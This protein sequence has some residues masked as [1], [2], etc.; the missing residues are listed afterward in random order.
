MSVVVGSGIAGLT[1]CLKVSEYLKESASESTRI[2]LITKAEKDETNT[3]YAQGGV[4]VVSDF[5]KD[6]FEKHIQ[7]TVNAGDY[8]ADKSM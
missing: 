4:A 5:F 3:K 2:C 6:S 7:D 8:L 1:Y